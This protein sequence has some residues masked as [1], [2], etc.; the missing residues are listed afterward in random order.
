IEEEMDFLELNPAQRRVVGPAGKAQVA[1]SMIDPLIRNEQFDRAITILRSEEVGAVMAP[2]DQHDAIRRIIIAQNRLEEAKGQSDADKHFN[3]ASR[4]ARPGA[5]EEEI[6]TDART[7]AGLEKSERGRFVEFGNELLFVED[8]TETVRVVRRGPTPEEEAEIE[9]RIDQAKTVANIRLMNQLIQSFGGRPIFGLP[10]PTAPVGEEGVEPAAPT[11]KGKDGPS[12]S[13]TTA[14]TGGRVGPTPERAAALEA[15]QAEAVSEQAAVLTPFGPE[16]ENAPSEDMQ[17][18]VALTLGS[19]V[20]LMM[21]KTA[22]ANSLLSHASFLMN[23]SPE[24]KR[25]EELDKLIGLEWA[26]KLGVPVGTTVRQLQNR[27]LPSAEEIQETRQRGERID[28][29]TA[30]EA[31]VPRTTTF[32]ELDAIMADRERS[33]GGSAV[34]RT[35]EEKARAGSL[36]SARGREQSD[37]EVQMRFVFEADQQTE[38]LLDEIKDDPTLVG[39]LGALRAT[40]RKALTLLADLGFDNLVDA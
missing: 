24:I 6:L 20:L 2:G 21:G 17:D 4:L 30:R 1:L 33:G 34:P 31:Q 23:N 10:P 12:A 28:L 25:N 11:G 39:T 29:N 40:G 18:V 13:S 22:E 36:A 38:D 15:D 37:A 14:P 32:G 27:I 8:D 26:G 9:I 19:R 3:T 5:T 16:P 7:L 35:F